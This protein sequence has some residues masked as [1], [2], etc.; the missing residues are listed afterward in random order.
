MSSPESKDEIMRR[1]LALARK[2]WGTTHPNPMVGAAIVE[3]GAIVAEGFHARADEPHAE[4]MALTALGRDPGPDAK[5]FVTMEP[6]STHGRTPPCTDAIIRSG[7][8]YVVVGA[9]DPNP[10][11]AGRGIQILKTAGISVETRVLTDECEDLNLIFNHWITRSQPLIAGK[12]AVTLDGRIATRTGDSKWITGPVARADVMSW[13]RLFPAIAVGAGTATIDQ[14]RLT[15]RIEGEEEWCP[16]RFI[17]DGI[18]RIAM[19]RQPCSLLRDE[20]RDRT[21]VVASEQAGTG[22]VRKL[23]TEGVNIW[24]LPGPGGK[25]SFSAFREKC[26]EAGIE[27][28]Y[29]EGGSQVLSELLHSRELDY[30]FVYRAPMLFGDD[31]ARPIFR[32][33]RTEKLEQAVRL[34]RVRHATAG[35]D[36]LM[37]GFVAY[38]GKLSVDE[39][40]FSNG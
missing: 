29:V 9:T 6:C 40:I 5:L 23:Q 25:V 16:V 21:I 26:A 35:D 36:Q 30:L 15:A 39:T 1:C 18:L 11:H 32:G 2:G 34:E 37:R 22:Y 20:F 13:R 17:F 4:V 14:P 31:R 33:L 10:E 19:E 27:G 3:D 8:K 38:P 7:I 12:V 24:T 28:V